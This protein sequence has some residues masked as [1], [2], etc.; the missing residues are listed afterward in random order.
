[1]FAGV[2]WSRT[3]HTTCVFTFSVETNLKSIS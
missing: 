1:M 2:L 3:V